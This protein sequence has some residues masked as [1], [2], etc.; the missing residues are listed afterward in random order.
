MVL[1]GNHLAV[2][3]RWTLWLVVRLLVLSLPA[4]SF[5][6]VVTICVGVLVTTWCLTDGEPPCVLRLSY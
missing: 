2:A 5:P 1:L 4:V 6:V 3:T